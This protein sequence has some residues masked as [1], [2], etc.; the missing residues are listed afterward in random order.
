[1]PICRVEAA[2]VASTPTTKSARNNPTRKLAGA[3]V[4]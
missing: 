1:M 2:V 3:Y 4:R